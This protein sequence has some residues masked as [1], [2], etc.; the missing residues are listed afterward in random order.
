MSLAREV[1]VGVGFTSQ[2][3]ALTCLENLADSVSFY[4]LIGT[5]GS[6]L[7]QVQTLIL[8]ASAWESGNLKESC[9][10]AGGPQGFSSL[11]SA[12][13][14]PSAVSS[15]C[16]LSVCPSDLHLGHDAANQGADSENHF[17][18][19]VQGTCI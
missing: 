16:G 10:L 5:S 8:R 9:A 1:G 15:G 14:Q 2:E 7:S 11:S 4:M 18:K 19:P 13:P 12:L 17:S 3:D 6:P